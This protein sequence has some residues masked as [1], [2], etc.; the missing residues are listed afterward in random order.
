M[1]GDQYHILL[2]ISLL[3]ASGHL[4]GIPVGP[5]ALVRLGGEQAKIVDISIGQ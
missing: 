3:C 5:A 1:R 4:V 2:S